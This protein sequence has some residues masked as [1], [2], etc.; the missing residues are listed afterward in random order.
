MK[1]NVVIFGANGFLGRYL[2]THFLNQSR[3]VVAVARVQDGMDE[4]AMSLPWDGAS[5][6]PW[7]LAMEGADLVIN[8][9]G[10]TVNCR[11][12]E[13]NRRR[14]LES[15]VR[16]TQAIGEA[17]AGC[18]NPPRVWM[19]AS[20]ATYY[21]HA[22]D[23]P[24]DEWGGEPG[25]GFSVGV[26][27]A[28]EETFFAMKVPGSVRKVALRTG[29]VLAMEKGTV[30]EVLSHLVKWGLGGAMGNGHQRMAWLHMDDFLG[31][32]D[33]LEDQIFLDGVVNLVAPDAPT[34][35]QF[36]AEMRR[37]WGMPIGMRSREWMLAMG[38]WLR[39]TEMELVLKSRWV[40][41]ARLLGEGYA[42]RWPALGQ[43]LADLHQRPG[44]RE[45]FAPRDCRSI[46]HRA[47]V[48]GHRVEPA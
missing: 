48:P 6:G 46:G 12:D 1:G 30:L 16:S 8:L 29:M 25:E 10:A 11:Y 47:W 14:I 19:N 18:R 34:N 3:E 15:R 38:T 21:R 27:R 7:A 22:E 28:W 2:T 39:G 13:E 40:E 37:E 43:A 36:M 23:G 42:F 45:F 26:V 32:V 20:S 9:A 5:Q 41:P 35:E 17:I 24:Q 31:V 4:R 33:W 44:L